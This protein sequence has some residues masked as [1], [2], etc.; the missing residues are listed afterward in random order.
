MKDLYRAF[1]NNWQDKIFMLMDVINCGRFMW[2]RQ[3]NFTELNDRREPLTM[4][5]VAATG[6]ERPITC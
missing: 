5:L 2:T 6:K 1:T 3:R 4:F